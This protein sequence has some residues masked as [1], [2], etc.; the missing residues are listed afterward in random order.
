MEVGGLRRER[1]FVGLGAVVI[2][3]GGSVECNVDRSE[4]PSLLNCLRCPGPGIGIVGGGVIRQVI[5]GNHAELHA[6]ASGKE[7]HFMVVAKPGEIPASI[8][9]LVEHPVDHR[10]TMAVFQHPD[11]AVVDIP[12]IFPNTFEHG[13]GHHSGASGEVEDPGGSG[14]HA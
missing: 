2:T 1:E 13:L 4:F 10:A 6:G 5:H 7:E 14:G 3:T 12:D 9:R 11:A 8:G